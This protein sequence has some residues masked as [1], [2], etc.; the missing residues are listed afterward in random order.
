MA[1]K[2]IKKYPKV[3]L[4]GRT[5]VGKSTLFNRLATDIESIAHKEAG[6]TRDYVSEVISWA[7]KQFELIDTGGVSYK[8][9][10]NPLL[11]K[12]RKKTLELFKQATFL[13]FVCDG[14]EGLTPEDQE[15]ARILHKTKKPVLLLLNKCDSKKTAANFADFYALGFKD[16]LPISG[17]H[18]KGIGTLLEKITQNVPTAITEE[19]V[20]K[21]AY[22]IVILGKPNV[23]KSS[24]LNLLLKKER[25]IVHELAG[26][27]REQISELICFAQDIIQVTDTA[28][29]RRKGRI[30]E[31]LETLMVKSTLDAVRKS[32]IILLVVDASEQQLSDQELKLLFYAFEQKKSLILIFNKTDLI[33]EEERKSLEYHLEEYEFILKKIPQLWIS[34]KTKKKTEKVFKEIEKAWIRRNQEF[35]SIELNEIIKE[36]LEK[37][38]MFHKTI[39]LKI[40]KI[41]QIKAFIPT[42]T[43]RV[44]R[45]QWFG[46]TQ[47][48]FIEN[49]L[50]KKYDL[51]G[52]PVK[53]IVKTKK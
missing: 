48:G 30:S 11:E 4:V 37:K 21:P 25:A 12:V 7:D 33:N 19:I 35:Y 39:L 16:I 41:S 17:I 38:P 14:K 10:A 13:L 40:F 43:L 5:N 28:G 44:N 42:F 6:V 3:L 53:F 20:E 27:T 45:P 1:T 15:I 24:L 51:K 46:P 9:Q 36:T 32:D 47:L 8:K 31:E 29:V 26:T 2:K 22:K 23:G 18:G 50:R 49:I 34:C 52:C